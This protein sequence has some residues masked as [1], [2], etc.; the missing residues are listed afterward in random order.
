VTVLS[1]KQKDYLKNSQYSINI[2]QGAVSSGK[3]FVAMIRFLEHVKYGPPGAMV[4]CGKS[5]R[6]IKQ[7][8]IM[9]MFDFLGNVFVYK[10]G[11]GEVNLWNRRIYLVGG[12]D[13]RSES[14]LRGATFAGG[15]VDEVTILPEPFYK[16]LLSRMRVEGSKL[17]VTTNPDSPHHWFKREF[18][19]RESELD[20]KTWA[21]TLDD[22]PDL[23]S[24][25]KENIKKLYTGIWYDRFIL[26][27]W[28][29]AEGRVYDMFDSSLHVFDDIKTPPKEY[30]VGVDYG[31][32]NPACFTLIGIN[33]AGYP[34]LWIEQE[35]YYDF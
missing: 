22:N 4:I 20:Q 9:P 10:E 7:N 19:D 26:G 13:A 1:E 25:Y 12:N 27:K 29:I 24:I 31:T 11:V 35:C 23:P 18:M 14:K 34:Y 33:P 15:L 30:I 5:E 17:F 21:F 32:V 6:T 3:S 16:M 2:A 28:T 8:I